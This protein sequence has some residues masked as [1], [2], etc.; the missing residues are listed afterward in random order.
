MFKD[1]V[2]NF[3]NHYGAQLSAGGYSID[4]HEH[5]PSVSILKMKS[6]NYFLIFSFFNEY[7]YRLVIDL[8]ANGTSFK[9]IDKNILLKEELAFFP[10]DFSKHHTLDTLQKKVG[11]RLGLYIENESVETQSY[12]STIYHQYIPNKYFHV[13]LGFIRPFGS[14]KVIRLNNF[15][16]NLT[17]DGQLYHT[18]RTY[19]GFTD[20]QFVYSSNND[21]YAHGGRS[22]KENELENLFYEL[23][24]NTIND[25]IIKSVDISLIGQPEEVVKKAIELYKM[26]EI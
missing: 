7:P 20:G 5:S 6:M 24:I 10:S 22:Y 13:D 12:N 17:K 26:I 15:T 2:N 14:K 23:F 25:D 11:I 9:E 16:I 1:L 18:A 8:K 19:F 21:V 4:S 3:L